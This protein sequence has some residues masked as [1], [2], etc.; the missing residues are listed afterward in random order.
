MIT[1]EGMELQQLRY[2]V[3]LADES[4][5][6]RAAARCF[7]AQSALSHSIK[8]LET[9]LGFA[10]F[11]RTSRR[12]ELTSAGKAFLP[13]ARESIR[14]AERAIADASAAEGHVSGRLSV[15]VI[16]T[17]TAVDVLASLKIYREAY[18]EVNL[19]FEIAGSD[20]LENAIARGTIDVGFLGLPENR[21]PRGVA[22]KKL[23]SNKLV[24]VV[25]D[26]HRLAGQAKIELRDLAD[27][28]FADFPAGSPARA[29][30][31]L[32]FIAAGVGRRVPFE[33][34][35]VN[36]TLDLV[37]HNLAI[38]LLP[39]RF[40]PSTLPVTTLE[41]ADGPSRHEYLA[42]SNFNPSP[43]ARA[44]IELIEMRRRD[45]SDSSPSL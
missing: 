7:V 16:P 18:P 32:A 33:S 13:S 27:E 12:V 11:N 37:L 3:A 9:E 30:S 36:L 40:V 24:A 15:G 39:A 22:S 2:V 43:A 28:T 19:T 21:P 41:I 5:F 14:A 10:L 8:N 45:D 42:W 1:I 29:E 17:V 25:S 38:A 35:A 20:E 34:M 23:G 44:F 26:E 6:T 31:D 4:S